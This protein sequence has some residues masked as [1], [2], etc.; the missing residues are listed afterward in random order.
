M[1][2]WTVVAGLMMACSG[3]SDDVVT[4]DETGETEIDTSE[5]VETGEE[6][7]PAPPCAEDATDFV[8]VERGAYAVGSFV[9]TYDEWGP[10]VHHVDAPDVE[11]FAPPLGGGWLRAAR[12]SLHVEEHQGSFKIEDT[13]E[14]SCSDLVIDDMAYRP[15]TGDLRLNGHF[16]DCASAEV[17]VTVCERETGHL[18]IDIRMEDPSWNELRVELGSA[19]DE[20]IFGMGVQ[21][22]H[23]GL[24][25]NGRE[26]PVLSQEGGVGRGH[27]VI[28]PLVELA[29]EG[30]GGSE[31][32]AYVATPQYITSEGRAIYLE[33][34]ELAIFDFRADDR[35]RLRL[36]SEQMRVRLPVGT[37]PLELVSSY[38][39]WAG[40]MPAP[41]DWV[42]EGAVVA[43][44]RPLDESLS[45]V[46]ELLDE[47]A[48]LAGVWNQTWSGVSETFIGEQVL[49][50]W[51]QDP[52]T[53]PGWDAWVDELASR[54]LRTLCYVNS[55]LRD[56]PEDYGTV[57]RNLYQ[58]ALEAG[59]FV[60]DEDGEPYLLPVTA[61]EVG[62]V[63]L[64]NQD[65]WRWFS[66][67]LREEMLDAAGCSG[68]MADFAEALPFDAVMA[69]GAS[70]ADWHNRYPVEW[71][72]L[73]REAVE[74]AGRL[75]D[76]HVFHR[77]GHSLSPRYALSLWQGDQLTTWDEYDGLISSVHQLIGGGFSGFSILHSDIGGYTSLSYLGLGYDREE[78]LLLRWTEMAAFTALMRTHEGNQPGANYQVYSNLTTRKHFARMTRIYRALAPYRRTVFEEAEAL[79]WPV[80]R[81]L[82]MHYP[83]DARAWDVSDAFLLGDAF[84][85]APVVEKCVTY[86]YGCSTRRTV[87]L[88]GDEAWVH[89]WS[90]TVYSG[91]TE[92][93]VEAPMGEPPVFYREGAEAGTDL[94]DALR[95]SNDL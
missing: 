90:G 75:G 95:A 46:D 8:A 18:G 57:R 83:D 82:V 28:T 65:A 81:H 94:V 37:E 24:D 93:E 3:G 77:S 74:E 16:D 44:A 63:D 91:G 68:W 87:Y 38:T 70:G 10:S 56:V 17:L 9:F 19:P 43:L 73:N 6:P 30:S 11:R 31:T 60:H 89:L 39:E 21:G 49:W 32:T 80:A 72:R 84:L 52:N 62:L 78:D 45:I 92:V 85:V 55:M 7:P 61:F 27:P 76:V 36:F 79:G 20:R 22:M 26:I 86:P 15:S 48:A 29:S 66:E 5:P 35:S 33:D 88:P 25:L 53:H 40:R 47:R 64:S 4:I 42:N 41:P 2:R 13:V 54:D 58:E 71:A 50:N 34:T 1:R 14:A 69:D 67:V 51:V 23:D 59:Y 12:T